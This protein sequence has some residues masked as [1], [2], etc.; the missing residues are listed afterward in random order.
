M[1]KNTFKSLRSSCQVLCTICVAIFLF[2]CARVSLQSV[3]E[4]SFS[5]PINNL[6]IN[7]NH[8]EVDQINPSY[9][10]YLMIALMEELSKKDVG[11]VIHNIG[12]IDYRPYRPAEADIAE[13]KID[14]VMTITATSCTR[15]GLFGG[16]IQI[17][18]DVNLF[19]LSTDE[20]I[21][22]AR[23][24][25]SGGPWVRKKFMK[26]MVN[27]LINRLSGEKLISSEPRLKGK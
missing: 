13:Y 1:K 11:F 5:E 3:R 17:I 4:P 6:L 20:R 27:D 8:R 9:T 16:F 7:L 19:D 22:R 23:I 26:L 18:Y 15:S 12:Q 21:W 25:A 24:N 14:K 10:T 2:G